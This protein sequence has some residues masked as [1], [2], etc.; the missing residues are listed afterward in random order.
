MYS[1]YVCGFATD[2]EKA[3]ERERERERERVRERNV[4]RGMR[5]KVQGTAAYFLV[6][7][8]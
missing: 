8:L 1:I 6:L 4:D 2:K 7:Y 3:R 5:K